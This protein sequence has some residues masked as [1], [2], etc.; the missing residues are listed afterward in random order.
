M[1]L[2]FVVFFHKSDHLLYLDDCGLLHWLSLQQL[3][4][5]DPVRNLQVHKLCRGRFDY[6]IFSEHCVIYVQVLYKAS[7]VDSQLELKEK[8]Y[9]KV[10]EPKNDCL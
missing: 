6:L 1:E 10:D 8:H 7:E 4:C 9:D 5:G 2:L 3:H